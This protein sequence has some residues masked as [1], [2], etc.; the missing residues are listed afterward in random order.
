MARSL[1]FRLFLAAA[2]FVGMLVLLAVVLSA[3]QFGLSLWQQL[4]SAPVWVVV[5]IATVASLMLGFGGWL[6]WLIVRP[7]EE[8]GRK[9]RGTLDRS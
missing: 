9:S 2:V 1:T 3:A 7:A 6:I 5:L 8:P 4:Q